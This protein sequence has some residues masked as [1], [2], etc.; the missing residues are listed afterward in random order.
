M[1]VTTFHKRVMVSSINT[2]LRP[3]LFTPWNDTQPMKVYEHLGK[4]GNSCFLFVDQSGRHIFPS[5][6][7]FFCV[8]NAMVIST[9]KI[10][11]K[12]NLLINQPIYSFEINEYKDHEIEEVNLN[13]TN[14]EDLKKLIRETLEDSFNYYFIE[15]SFSV[16]GVVLN[17][18]R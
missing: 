8:G 13:G 10:L 5:Q 7:T 11:L 18:G 1:G 9:R 2:M 17:R 14:E 12:K 3:L 6:G 15:R 16:K 4:N